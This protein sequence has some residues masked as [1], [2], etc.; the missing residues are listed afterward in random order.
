VRSLLNQISND[1]RDQLLDFRDLNLAASRL[2]ALSGAAPESK[3]DEHV[4]DRRS[5]FTRFL[6]KK[7]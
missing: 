6:P 3:G 1:T 7:D 5:L 4:F 2:D